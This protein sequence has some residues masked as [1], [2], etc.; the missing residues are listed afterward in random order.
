[1]TNNKILK[2]K[3]T[4]QFYFVFCEFHELIILIFAIKFKQSINII[5]QYLNTTIV[6]YKFYHVYSTTYFY[7]IKFTRFIKKYIDY[8]SLK[9]VQ[10][11]KIFGHK[12]QI[13]VFKLSK[14]DKLFKII[15]FHYNSASQ[16]YFLLILDFFKLWKVSFF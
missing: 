11:K 5:H 14:T 7:Y 12:F 13:I 15:Y 8:K 4:N 1:M 2:L 6:Y 10:K 16:L 3:I 9:Q